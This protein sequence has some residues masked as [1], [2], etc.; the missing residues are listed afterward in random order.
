LEPSAKRV[1]AVKNWRV[2][3]SAMLQGRYGVLGRSAS[4]ERFGM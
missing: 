1:E 4:A 2:R 3:I